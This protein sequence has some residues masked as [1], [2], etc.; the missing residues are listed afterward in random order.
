MYT[1]EMLTVAHQTRASK[2]N[3]R[4]WNE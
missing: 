3:T 4:Q 2:G 1:V